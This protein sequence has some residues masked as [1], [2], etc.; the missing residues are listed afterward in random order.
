MYLVKVM[1][2]RIN[3]L[4]FMI[5]HSLWKGTGQSGTLEGNNTF[6]VVAK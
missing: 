2:R 4:Q 1:P 6:L 5:H 3:A